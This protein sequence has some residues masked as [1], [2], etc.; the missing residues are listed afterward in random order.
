M[1]GNRRSSASAAL[2]ENADV[3]L[4]LGDTQYD[5]GGYQRFAPLD[6]SGRINRDRGVREFLAESDKP[7]TDS[8]TTNCH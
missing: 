2:L 4:P 8:G 7:F 3:V 6:P 5:N 1:S